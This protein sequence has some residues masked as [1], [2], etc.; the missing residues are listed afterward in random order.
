MF[1][2]SKEIT[3]GDPQR[4]TIL[5]HRPCYLLTMTKNQNFADK[6]ELKWHLPV[7][8]K[9]SHILMFLKKI[10]FVTLTDYI[11]KNVT[12]CMKD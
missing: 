4:S 9:I 3:V 5:D 6:F 12:H 1:N 2:T 8:V 11:Q 7:S 10:Y